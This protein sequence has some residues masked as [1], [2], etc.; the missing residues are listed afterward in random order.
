MVAVVIGRNN[1]RSRSSCCRDK[2]FA[3]VINIVMMVV[4]V[5]AASG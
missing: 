5:F 3:G 1:C 2:V 4:V